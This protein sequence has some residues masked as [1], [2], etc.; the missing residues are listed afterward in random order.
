MYTN[1]IIDPSSIYVDDVDPLC[2]S[3][4]SP[5]KKRYSWLKKRPNQMLQEF[6][7]SYWNNLL[8]SIS[9]EH[10]IEPHN[11]ISEDF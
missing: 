3:A 9:L 1:F 11:T 10:F 5:E 7:I 6:F 8:W 2:S 4:H